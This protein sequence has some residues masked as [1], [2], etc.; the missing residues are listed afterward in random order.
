M[1]GYGPGTGD[2]D[3]EEM[4]TAPPPAKKRTQRPVDVVG[5]T[6]WV[7]DSSAEARLYCRQSWGPVSGIFPNSLIGKQTR[8]LGLQIGE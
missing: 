6:L 3:A 5:L 4:D 8:H 2:T 7:P 1:R